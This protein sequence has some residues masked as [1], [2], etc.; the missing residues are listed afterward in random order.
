M[1]DRHSSNQPVLVSTRLKKMVRFFASLFSDASKI[2]GVIGSNM[3]AVLLKQKC[4]ECVC[5]YGT[6]I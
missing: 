1:I 6:S 5:K 2:Y 4:T 3:F